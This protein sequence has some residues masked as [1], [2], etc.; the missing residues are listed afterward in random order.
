MIPIRPAHWLSLS[1]V[2]LVLLA[3]CAATDREDGNDDAEEQPIQGGQLEGGEPAVGMLVT[4]RGS[5]CTGELIAP[6]VILTAAHCIDEPL[7]AFYTGA[8]APLSRMRRH[9]IRDKADS[10]GLLDFFGKH[11]CPD[12]GKDIAV[13]RLAAPVRDIEPLRIGDAMPRKGTTCRSVGFGRHN[14]SV[15][16]YQGQTKRSADMTVRDVGIWN[17]KVAYG[18]GITD[19]GDSGGPLLCDG[20]VVGITNCHRDGDYPDHKVSY[21]ARVDKARRFI[22][23]KVAR[24]GGYAR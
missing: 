3:G 20:E 13:V 11:V 21:F 23:D 12:A 9:A 16:S 4:Q 1:A 7:D 8:G 2:S 17:L 22:D 18:T 14:T 15:D 24:W 10:R 19:S 6:E 5:Y